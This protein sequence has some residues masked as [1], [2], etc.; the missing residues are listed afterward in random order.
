MTI[1]RT[2]ENKT[3][4]HFGFEHPVTLFVF[5]MTSIFH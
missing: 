2:L 3:V 4:S 5:R 1:I